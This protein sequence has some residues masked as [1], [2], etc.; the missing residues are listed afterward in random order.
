MPGRTVSEA[1]SAFVTPLADALSCVLRAKITCTPGG[2]AVLDTPHTLFITGNQGDSYL[3]LDGCRLELFARIYYKLI[4]DSRDGY[5]RY[6]ATT[7]GYDYSIRTTDGAAVLDF[8]WHPSANSHETRPHTHIGSS[9]LATDSVL[10]NKIH[11]LGSRMTFE[12]VV[13]NVIALGAKPTSDDYNDLLA[14]C[15]APHLLHRTW[16][17]DRESEVQPA[18]TP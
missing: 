7:L 15:E 12:N 18:D 6:R 10:S 3:R 14:I 16:H 9:Q 13:R 5:G 17:H 8:H 2:W 4:E 11:V 1:Y